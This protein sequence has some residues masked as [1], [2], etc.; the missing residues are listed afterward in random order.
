[1]IARKEIYDVD[2]VGL[3]HCYSR[4]VRRAYLCGSDALT[5][6]NYDHRKQ[7]IEELLELAAACHIVDVLAFSVLDNHFHLVLRNRPDLKRKLTPVA[8]ARRWLLLHPKRRDDQGR[9]CEPTRKE[10]REI[11]QDKKRVA[12]LRRRL[13]NISWFVGYVK[14]RLARRANAEDQVTGTFFEK[15]FEMRR[16]LSENAVLACLIYV[17]LNPIRAGIA[18]T[19]ETSMHTSVYRRIKSLT[20]RRRGKR[21]KDAQLD[22]WLSPV[23]DREL[24][25]YQRFA[26]RGCRASDDPVLSMTLEQYLHLLDWSGRQLK[27]GTAGKIPD[28]L[29]PILE[30]LGIATSRW[31]DVIT[32]F[33]DL[34]RRVAGEASDVQ[35]HAEDH[36]KQWFHGLENCRQ[37]FGSAETA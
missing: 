22:R 9:A 34:F 8:V 26:E 28:H 3:Y 29:A 12:E 20:A 13:A 11:T 19:P 2:E 25:A 32:N 30:R 5:G 15:R 37:I 6:K 18:K 7:W 24:P 16:L 4:C 23:H 36:Q 1:M 14:E 10:L 21:S 33:A 31:L 27:L 17:D 35:R